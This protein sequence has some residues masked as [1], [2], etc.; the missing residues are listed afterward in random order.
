M[1]ESAMST[2]T[3]SAV[4]APDGANSAATQSEK[5]VAFGLSLE[6]D[7]GRL[8]EIVFEQAPE[9]RAALGKIF[10]FELFEST[11]YIGV[12]RL[13]FSRRD[14]GEHRFDHR[15]KVLHCLPTRLTV[16]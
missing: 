1:L 3:T 8:R 14:T 15:H 12:G 11:E 2:R 5:S 6:V 10:R 9:R 13:R 4:N 7:N 16:T